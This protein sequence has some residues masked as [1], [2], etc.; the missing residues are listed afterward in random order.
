[1]IKGGRK[2]NTRVEDLV[3]IRPAL[4][5]ALGTVAGL[6]LG[7]FDYYFTLGLLF[8][9]AMTG[10]MLR[11][12]LP[13]LSLFLIFAAL[14]LFRMLLEQ[15]LTWSIRDTAFFDFTVEL[16]R[17]M[18][19]MIA[20]LFGGDGAMVGGLLLG[21]KLGIPLELYDV[22]K[23]N[24]VAHLFSV[25]G[26]HISVISGALMLLLTGTNRKFKLAVL[27]VFLLFYCCIT[28]LSPSVV[29]ASVTILVLR[30]AHTFDRPPDY[31]SASCLALAVLLLLMPS[32]A[33][34]YGFVLSFC[35]IY[36]L[37][38]LSKPL[39]RLFNLSGTVGS[40]VCSC[41]AVNLALLP[42]F[43]EFFGNISATALPASLI[44]MPLAPPL[45]ILS[46]LSVAVGFIYLP[47]A[48][49]I[50][51]LPRGLAFL[52]KEVFRLIDV[53][54]LPVP[55]PNILVFVFWFAGLFL[56]SPYYLPNK[57]KPPILGLCLIGAAIAAWVVGALIGWS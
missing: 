53:G 4:I 42:W 40:I 36:G 21:R 11:K 55:R 25:S 1:M 41:L 44:A 54:T 49:V 39:G 26:L 35:S 5:I 33:N 3:H 24:G 12:K 18:E 45:I 32:A 37:L 43:G 15:R 56:V 31:P 48:R 29:R 47:A 30:L 50:A 57:R 13:R 38:T 34:D 10:I 28:N 27:T 6:L 46:L 14:M 9:C 17:G 8:V 19:A 2:V 22:F 23:S 20:K 7:Q 51:L 52:L 16:R